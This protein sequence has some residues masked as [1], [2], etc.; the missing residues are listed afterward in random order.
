MVPAHL[1]L[2]VT[3]GTQLPFDRLVGA[4]ETWA[5]RRDMTEHVFVQCGPTTQPPTR[6]GWKRFIDVTECARRTDT[7]DVIV[8]HAGMGTILTALDRGKP[9]IVLPRRADLGEH[10][11][12]HQLATARRLQHLRQLTVAGDTTV[13]IELLD[14]HLRRVQSRGG[15]RLNSSGNDCVSTTLLGVLRSQLPDTQ[16]SDRFIAS[17]A[18]FSG[19]VRARSPLR[20]EVGSAAHA[21]SVTPTP[22]SL[23]GRLRDACLLTLQDVS[24]RLRRRESGG[25][26]TG[27][28]STQ[29][30]D[31]A[32]RPTVNL[33]RKDDPHVEARID[34]RSTRQQRE[35]VVNRA[36]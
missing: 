2:F 36:A 20:L 18:A 21:S 9:V 11:N 6:I 12:D 23:L 27:P 4:V 13:L 28:V 33:R 19:L 32:A 15:L 1:N 24:S 16:A 17:P 26:A 31:A 10:R 22:T 5:V 29:R 3:V 35:T 14:V 7:A 8:G 34:P 25:V 30:M